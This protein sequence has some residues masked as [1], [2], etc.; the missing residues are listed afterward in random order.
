ML[1]RL[2]WLDPATDADEFG[3]TQPSFPSA[4]Q[5]FAFLHQEAKRPLHDRFP[6]A[7][8]VLIYRNVL[9]GH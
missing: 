5:D 1:N 4:E 9:L 7:G 8:K 6:D 2:P 3:F